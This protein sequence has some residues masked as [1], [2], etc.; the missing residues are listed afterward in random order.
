VSSPASASSTPKVVATHPRGLAALAFILL[1]VAATIAYLVSGLFGLLI[2]ALTPEPGAAGYVVIIKG[3]LACGWSG[4]GV[5]LAWDA[6]HF[7]W[8]F[9]ATPVAAWAL[10]LGGAT[11]LQGSAFLNIGY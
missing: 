11:M 5:W 9:A 2:L 8:R 7:S 6:W 1:V 10:M 4:I 3:V